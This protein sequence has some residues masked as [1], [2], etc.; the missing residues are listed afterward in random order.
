MAFI[1]DDESVPRG[2]LSH[3][4][5]PG[6]ALDHD[7][8]HYTLRLAAASTQLADFLGIEFEVGH[9]TVPPLVDQRLS[10]H[11]DER[12]NVVPGDEPAADHRLP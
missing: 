5:T 11:E 1:D 3:I 12:R 9:Q 10:V 2:E 7:H 4:I 8:I 6:E